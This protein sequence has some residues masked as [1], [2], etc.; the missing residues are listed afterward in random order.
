MS[1]NFFINFG[2]KNDWVIAVWKFWLCTTLCIECYKLLRTDPKLI[3][4]NGY[5]SV[6]FKAKIYEKISKHWERPVQFES[7][8]KIQKKIWG[9]FRKIIWKS[10]IWRIIIFRC[11]KIAY[12]HI[13]LWK[14]PKLFFWFFFEDSNCTSLSQCLL[15]F[16]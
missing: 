12:F 4:S 9:D 11:L 3:F 14:S 10:A 7:S 15:I 8:K 16:S 6:I 2:F 1:A 13:I 5:N